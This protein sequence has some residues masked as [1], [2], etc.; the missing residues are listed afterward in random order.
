[1][2]RVY[3][4]KINKSLYTEA[5]SIL[6]R[7]NPT[8]TIA[9]TK[10]NSLLLSQ[11]E[12]LNLKNLFQQ[13]P[14][15]FT[16]F[17]HQLDNLFVDFSKNTISREIKTELI[18]LAEE[19]KLSESI[20]LLFGG[21]KIN[22][23]E[24]RAVLHT[25][26]RDFETEHFDLDGQDI[27]LEIKE[28]REKIKAL[29]DKFESGN[30]FGH[31]GQRIKTIVNIGIGGSHL[32]PEAVVEALSPFRN[33]DVSVLFLSNSDPLNFDDIKSK[34]KLEETVFIVVSKTFTTQETL[35]NADLIKQLYSNEAVEKHFFAVTAN[36]HQAISFGI[37]QDNIFKMWDWV[38]GRF[39]IWGSV[40][41][42]VALSIGYKNF[43]E[44]LKGAFEVDTHFRKQPFSGNIPVLMALIG[45]WNTN[46]M[47]Y[48]TEAIIPYSY[49]LQKLPA[50]IRQSIMESNGK[51]IDRNGDLIDYKTS[52]IIW[53]EIGTNAQHSF[54]QLL[55]QGTVVSPVDFIIA[56]NSQSDNQEQHKRFFSHFIAQSEALLNGT[57]Q[58]VKENDI[59]KYLEGN[60][61][62]T[63]IVLKQ[64][65]PFNL[66]SLLALYEHK[67]FTQGVIWN[68]FSFDQWGVE[69]GKKLAKEN[70]SALNVNHPNNT[71]KKDNSTNGLIQLY[72]KWANKQ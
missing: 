48:S 53:G 13:N 46:F 66:G 57:D 4:D 60:K 37:P 5:K 12:E 36:P 14:N 61:P 64:L 6:P 8:E 18:Q 54:L 62:S 67:I 47:N 52:P 43:E 28:E 49:S 40:G 27:M 55:H 26:L 10:L 2:N 21:A 41:L 16:D 32:G 3:T 65:T 25:L 68:I 7:V 69:L 29:A 51:S 42:S 63:S 50:F 71:Y 15:R 30:L 45:I 20:E 35:D 38:C 22:E 70:E 34:I 59:Q 23:T 19:C 24:N 1:M 31:T 17:S 56:I 33:K 39:S 44:M 72:E 9:W 58:E 11:K